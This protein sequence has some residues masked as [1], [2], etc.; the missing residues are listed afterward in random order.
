MPLAVMMLYFSILAVIV[1]VALSRHAIGEDTT[2]TGG[3]GPW[4]WIKVPNTDDELWMW[5]G[6]KGWEIACYL[7]TTT[8]YILLKVRLVWY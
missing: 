8:L 7:I 5:L 2:T 6:G 4:C 3:T 1:G